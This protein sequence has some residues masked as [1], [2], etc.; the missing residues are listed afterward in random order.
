MSIVILGALHLLTHLI[1]KQPYVIITIISLLEKTEE[2]APRT[3]DFTGV[4]HE[5]NNLISYKLEKHF[6]RLLSRIQVLY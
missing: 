5:S 3:A 2:L 4:N 6:S 1:I